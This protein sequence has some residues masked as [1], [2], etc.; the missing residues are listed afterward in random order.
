MPTIQLCWDDIEMD[1]INKK[2]INHIYWDFSITEKKHFLC[3]PIKDISD[4]VAQNV[5]TPLYDNTDPENPVMLKKRACNCGIDGL[6]LSNANIEDIRNQK[7]IV[8]I[9]NAETDIDHTTIISLKA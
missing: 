9:L 4:D 5:I 1:F 7:K 2:R 6:V 3:L 8:D